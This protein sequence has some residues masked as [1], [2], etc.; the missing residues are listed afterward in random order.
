MNPFLILS[1]GVSAVA[2]SMLMLWRNNIV[3]AARIKSIELASEASK[4]IIHSAMS[5]KW[6]EAYAIQRSYGTYD[7]MM[8]MFTKWRFNHFY[9]MLEVRLAEL[10]GE[11]LIS[12]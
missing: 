8:W 10:E 9:P 7:Q 5:D 12:R 4:R 3:Y 11:L 1:V 2:F 6:R